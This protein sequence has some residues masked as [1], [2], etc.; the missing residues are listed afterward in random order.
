M[1]LETCGHALSRDAPQRNRFAARNLGIG[2]RWRRRWNTRVMLDHSLPSVAVERAGDRSHH[3]A[4]PCAARVRIQ[5]TAHVRR[6]LTG[7]G[8]KAATVAATPID[9]VTGG[10]HR[11]HRYRRRR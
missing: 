7:N 10:A 2:N 3:A 6:A 5:S 1:A 11:L 8:W 4:I 9:P